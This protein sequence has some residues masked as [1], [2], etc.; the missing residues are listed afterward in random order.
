MEPDGG[1]LSTVL[2]I[3]VRNANNLSII[4]L[5]LK[6]KH[7]QYQNLRNLKTQAQEV[8]SSIFIFNSSLI[9]TCSSSLNPRTFNTILSSSS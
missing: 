5:H 7:G 2:D 8:R 3:F 6:I 4:I 1:H 9:F